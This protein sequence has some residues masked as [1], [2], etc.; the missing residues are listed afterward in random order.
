MLATAFGA[1]AITRNPR[2]PDEPL[3]ITPFTTD[4]GLKDAP[5][6]SPDGERVACSDASRRRRQGPLR[7][8]RGAGHATDAID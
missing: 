8:G 4:G 3:T 2:E 1:W 6:L 5:R 7:E